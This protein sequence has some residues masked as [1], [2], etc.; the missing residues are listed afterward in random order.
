MIFLKLGGSLITDKAT[1]NSARTDVLDRIAGEIAAFRRQQ[2]ETALLI[3]HGSGSFGHA[4][5]A[6]WQAQLDAVGRQRWEAFAEVWAAAQS[7]N[8]RVV[9]SLRA[10]G[11]PA[12]SLP[13][14]ASAVC[15][16][17]E[18]IELAIEPIEECLNAGVVP[19]V[20]GDVAVDRQRGTTIVSTEQVLSYLVGPLRPDRLLLAGSEAGVYTDYPDRQRMLDVLSPADLQAITLLGADNPDVTGGM[21][22]KVRRSLALAERYPTLEI[23]IFSGQP[24]GSIEA[25]LLGGSPGTLI[26][27]P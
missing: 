9:D 21:A 11:L 24:A 4:A 22:D 26:R 13:P 18:L 2:P 19:I 20:Y 12:L 6:K 14:S 8:R 15:R 1:P 23:R 10:A 3:G 5:A 7:L 16:D 17:G 25:V 27:H